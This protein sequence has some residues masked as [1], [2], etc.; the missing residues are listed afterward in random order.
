MITR[1]VDVLVIGAGLSGLMA[2]AKAAE[3]GKKVLIAAKGMG[4][5][6]LSSGCIDLWGYSLDDPH[7]VCAD[8]LS[9]V[10]KLNDVNPGHPYVRVQD[11]IQESLNFFQEICVQND[12]PYFT[13][14]GANWVLPTALGTTR[15]T[16]LA[17]K[18]MALGSLSSLDRILVVGFKELKDFYPEVLAANLKRSGELKE[19]CELATA[20]INVGAEEQNPNTLAYRLEQAE[21]MN[22]VISQL[23]PLLKPGTTLLFPP[24]LGDRRD[25]QVTANLAKELGCQVYETTNIPPALP[26]QR[27]QNN[28]LLHLR[29]GGVE[30]INGCIVKS[31]KVSGKRCA[32]VTAAGLHREFTICAQT[33]VLATGS[34]LGGGLEAGPE[35]VRECIFD[36]PVK[37]AEGKR[38]NRGFLDIEGHPFSKFGVA[39]NE[40]LQPVDSEGQ[41]LIENVLV[42]GANIAGSNYPVEKCGNGVAIATGYKAGKLAGRAG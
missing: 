14:G 26:G 34:F 4:A 31:A 33:Y 21:T 32:W 29:L 22:R 27:L 13:N 35:S 3:Q 17:P 23:K 1:N 25:S 8:P 39:V 7:R 20:V 28:L 15:P 5:L 24:V 42:T 12:N 2:A 11:V 9:E 41:V 10:V 36:L 6:S 30:I 18:S 40:C 38:S 16:F 19:S 37:T